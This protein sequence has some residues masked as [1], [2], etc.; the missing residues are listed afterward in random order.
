M[1][2][3][4]ECAKAAEAKAGESGGGNCAAGAA[5]CNNAGMAGHTPGAAAAA[6][7]ANSPL[8]ASACLGTPDNESTSKVLF[9]NERLRILD[10]T[11]PYGKVVNVTHSAPTV[12]WQVVGE[13]DEIPMPSFHAA[14]TCTQVANNGSATS[15]GTR[16]EFLF[17]IVQGAPRYTEDRVRQLLNAPKFQ[18]DVGSKLFLETDLVRMWDFHSP[19]GM[20]EP[21][22]HVLDYAFVVIG[23]NSNLHLFHPNGIAPNGTQY[24]ETFSFTDGQVVFEHV[25]SG[26]FEAD[27]TTPVMPGCLHSVDTKGFAVE[28]REYLIEL[29]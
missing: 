14:N 2:C 21:H 8:L 15:S 19:I 22:H 1:L 11:L 3:Q 18:S 12:R 17:E 4:I 29:K 26:G 9:A 13:H 16:R 20:D 7:A 28:F 10:W 27:G 25:R 5:N 6:G 23:N 24:D